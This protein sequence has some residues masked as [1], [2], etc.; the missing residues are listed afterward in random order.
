MPR[1]PGKAENY[2]F[3]YSRFSSVEAE[4]CQDKIVPDDGGG[5]GLPQ[6]VLRQLPGELQEAFRLMQIG[7]QTGDVKAQERANELA[8]K[9]VERGGPEMQ[10]RFQEEVA[11]QT[12]NNPEAKHSVQDILANSTVKGAISSAEERTSSLSSTISS[13]QTSM[14]AGQERAA[15]QLEQMQKKIDALQQLRGPEDFAR[16]MEE[17]GLTQE[18][19]Q[20]ALM[21]D[22]AQVQRMVDKSLGS[23]NPS[24][25]ETDKINAILGTVEDV[26]RSLNGLTGKQTDQEAVLHAAEPPRQLEQKEKA[27][28]ASPAPIIP[29]HRV[30]Y[31]KDPSGNLEAV[32][33][34]CE[35]PGVKSMADLE[36]DV[37]SNHLRVRALAPPYVVNVGPFPNL[38]DASA[39]RA[40]F[41][42]KREEL[43][44]TVPAVR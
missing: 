4:E 41:S 40:K 30:Q 43:S 11:R 29:E 20:R 24:A 35:L 33:L 32:E 31:R 2:N 26:H 36:V 19:M 6:D 7:A 8:L 16:F 42:R 14:K 39:A 1:G 38:V 12:M 44:L 13:L 17:E 15:S 27:V 28:T 23:F 25:D 18:D 10:R 37:A 5:S 21:G 9:A 34:R 22:E 3:D